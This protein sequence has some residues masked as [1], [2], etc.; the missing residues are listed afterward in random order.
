MNPVVERYD[1]LVAKRGAI[2]GIWN[3]VE[4]YC[5]PYKASFAVQRN[6][7]NPYAIYDDTI[8]R[9]KKIL[10]SGLYSYLTNPASRWF[11]LTVTAPNST[12]A[13]Q[14]WCAETTDIALAVIR[15]SN[16]YQKIYQFYDD[17]VTYG[18]A[19]LY[20]EMDDVTGLVKFMEIYPRAFV[21]NRNVWG[22]VD[23]VIVSIKMTVS[24]LVEKFGNSVSE[25][26]KAKVE[27]QPKEMVNVLFS[28]SRQ[29]NSK[30]KPYKSV[31]I[32]KETEHI[33]KEG[34]YDTFPFFVGQWDTSSQTL[35]GSSP[36]IEA[37]P[38]VIL[39]NRI[40]KTFWLNNEKLANPPLDVPYQ[41]Y[42]GDID[43]TPG[44]IN[45]RT[46]PN[47]Q[48]GIKPIITTGNINIDIESLQAARQ[49]INE[50]M[51]VD[52]FLLDK[53]TTMT[54]T[55]VI[56][57]TQEKMLLLG[58]V[59]GRL[60]HEVL[61]PLVYR[62]IVLLINSGDLDKPPQPFNI[63][64]LSPLAQTQKSSEYQSLVVLLNTV[65]QIAQFNPDIIDNVNWDNFI[66]KVANIYS[67]DSRLLNDE[68]TVAQVRQQ[69]QQAQMAQMQ[70]QLEELKGKAMKQ[71]A[72]AQLN[73]K[74]SEAI[75]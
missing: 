18:V 27:N 13:E 74:K 1:N 66:R 53:D 73:L 11:A 6:L 64:F 35:Y 59:I 26:V 42:Y 56:Q 21:F 63:E 3:D 30:G 49:T 15:E 41:G 40:T 72:Q 67:V 47:P 60:L 51:F 71:Q 32:E 24:E 8:F 45:Y 5:V 38:S 31:W 61:A 70:L 9:A 33:L 58:S 4:L 50:K 14:D 39:A 28:V 54:A 25:K 37:L 44:A 23:E 19:C 12:K 75:L 43:I 62:T 34:G 2:E 17:L 20:E 68:D 55:E 7:P 57:R 10:I 46:D 36:T 52:L 22:E 16:F 69:R 65:L 29:Y 48:N